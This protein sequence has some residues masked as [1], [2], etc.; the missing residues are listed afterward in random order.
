MNLANNTSSILL[1]NNNK[2]NYNSLANVSDG[3]N[4]LNG[5]LRL[6]ETITKSGTQTGGEFTFTYTIST[7]NVLFIHIYGTVT[8]DLNKDIQFYHINQCP[9]SIIVP[10]SANNSVDY[11]DY[12][13]ITKDFHKIYFKI[14]NNAGQLQKTYCVVKLITDIYKY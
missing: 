4:F 5:N 8:K 9:N 6:F 13:W 11:F 3:N 2:V 12:W 14:C 7:S 1:I 10:A